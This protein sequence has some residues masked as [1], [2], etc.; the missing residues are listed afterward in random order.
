MSAA[1]STVPFKPVSKADAAETLGVST[2]TIDNYIKSGLLPA[3][4]PFGG[5]ELWHPDIFYSCLHDA[6]MPAPGSP[7]GARS[8]EPSA[9]PFV[10]AVDAGPKPGGKRLR[11]SSPMVRQK[12]RQAGVLDDLNGKR[13]H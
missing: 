1:T 12:Q 7:A 8:S 6:L 11:D 5:R 13:S 10:P 2:K 4:R 3:P 9:A